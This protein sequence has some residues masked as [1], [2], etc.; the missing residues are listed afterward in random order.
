M[1]FI[2]VFIL[3]LYKKVKCSSIFLVFTLNRK[4]YSFEFKKEWYLVK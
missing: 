3:H 1:L 2:Y 4:N